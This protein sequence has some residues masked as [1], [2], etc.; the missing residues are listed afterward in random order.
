MTTKFFASG[1]PVTLNPSTTSWQ[2][3]NSAA[4]SPAPNVGDVWQVN[5]RGTFSAGNSGYLLFYAIAAGNK[6]VLQFNP[7]AVAI[8]RAYD[9]T[10]LCSV[11]SSASLSGAVVQCDGSL[12]W[13]NDAADAQ[14]VSLSTSTQS[15]NLS[16][17]PLLST[18]HKILH[19]D[20]AFTLTEQAAVFT[21]VAS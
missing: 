8:D 5:A 17:T 18:Q 16:G 13:S 3:L 11:R 19:A 20:A 2:T 9:V 10:A 21:V 6:V 12:R 7:V 15:V 14:D 4:L 1:L